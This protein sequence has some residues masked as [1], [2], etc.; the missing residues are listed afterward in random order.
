MNRQAGE[1]PA[2]PVL[3]LFRANFTD[4]AHFPFVHPEQDQWIVESQRPEQVP[5]DLS[6]ELHLK[7]DAV[8]VAY[9]RALS[10]F[11]FELA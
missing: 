9:R 2:V 5:F 7:F 4:F 3:P 10:D 11:G 8:A 6:E 1:P